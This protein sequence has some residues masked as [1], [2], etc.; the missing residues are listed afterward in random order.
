M[1]KIG[2]FSRGSIINTNIAYFGYVATLDE[3]NL[4][5]RPR[6]LVDEIFVTFCQWA[7]SK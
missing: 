1:K 4:D 7:N 3:N 5:F 2:I 6:E